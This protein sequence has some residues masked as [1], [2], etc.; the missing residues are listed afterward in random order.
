MYVHVYFGNLGIYVTLF[1]MFR[2]QSG[3][4]GASVDHHVSKWAYIRPVWTCG[5]VY[6]RGCVCW[7]FSDLDIT[8]SAKFKGRWCNLFLLYDKIFIIIGYKPLVTAFAI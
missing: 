6:V 7:K 1:G 5:L 4:T 3:I 2:H 8:P